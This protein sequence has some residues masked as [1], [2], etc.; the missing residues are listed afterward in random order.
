MRRAGLVVALLAIACVVPSRASQLP[1]PQPQD[2]VEFMVAAAERYPVVELGRTE[3]AGN[4]N[5]VDLIAHLLANRRFTAN[6]DDVIIEACNSRYQ[7]ML[8][9]YVS[10]KY[11]PQQQ[12]TVV[13]RKTTQITGG[14]A[15][16]TTKMLIDMVRNF[17]LKAPQHQLRVLAADP[18]IDWNA[19]HT[20]AQFNAFLSQRDA[21]AASAIEKQV[22][23]KHRRVLVV[24]GGAHF[25][26]RASPHYGATITMVLEPHYP[27]S[28]YVIY[29]IADVSRF[30]ARLRRTFVSWSAPVIAPIAGTAVALQ[31]G[32]T[33]TAGDVMRRVGSRWV[34]VTNAY[35]GYTLG[36]LFDAILYLGP[37]E[38][39]RTIELKEPTDQP[40]ATE[41]KRVRSIVMGTPSPL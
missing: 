25:T 18:P 13:W 35:P 29:D 8:D 14:E 33:I 27:G 12:L 32:R 36:R 4:A 31:S 26:R 10:G 1:G 15:D 6:I 22:L 38:K 21:Y 2:A 30:D 24:M 3:G 9:R 7:G 28:T 19:I 34:A 40:Y 16:Q 11:V 23:S 5:E 20:A 17:N 37:A 39:L 41:L